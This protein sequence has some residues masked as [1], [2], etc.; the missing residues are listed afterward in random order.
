MPAS[1]RIEENRHKNHDRIRLPLITRTSRGTF[2][3]RLAR[4]LAGGQG[5][6]RLSNVARFIKKWGWRSSLL[7]SLLLCAFAGY[8]I[9][10]SII[11]PHAPPVF[12]EYYVTTPQAFYA[13]G[14]Y[15][16]LE[17]KAVVFLWYALG[18]FLVGLWF[19]LLSIR[20]VLGTGI[21]FA[22]LV[23]NVAFTWTSGLIDREIVLIPGWFPKQ[24]V[25]EYLSSIQFPVNHYA[26]LDEYY[27]AW[28]G[29]LFAFSMAF[30]RRGLLPRLV[31]SLELASLILLPLPIEV[32]LFDRKQFTNK[33]MNAQT[34]TSLIWFTN[35]DLLGSLL[36]ILVVLAIVDRKLLTRTP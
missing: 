7:A 32:Y 15:Y 27:L 28:L 9:I 30:F 34:H 18:A 4:Q 12:Y 25:A 13:F 2:S 20:L 21:G 3:T 16:G 10:R 26:A 1:W 6:G 11:T 17:G 19:R 14:Q 35:A 36:V 8:Y 24:F 31:H 33:V 5:R 22:T 23:L 29:I